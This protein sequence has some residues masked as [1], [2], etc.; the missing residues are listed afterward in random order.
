MEWFCKLEHFINFKMDYI[1][2]THLQM[3]LRLCFF[4]S[5]LTYT[6]PW[7][8]AKPIISYFCETNAVILKTKLFL[9]H[10]R[11]I[12]VFGDVDKTEL[13]NRPNFFFFTFRLL[14]L[15]IT[16]TTTNN[17]SFNHTNTNYNNSNKNNKELSI[18]RPRWTEKWFMFRQSRYW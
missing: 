10:K 12:L 2:E 13:I 11:G 7:K 6:P 3:Y 1:V 5:K 16:T 9:M 8:C 14:S 17:R 18:C 15:L 4:S